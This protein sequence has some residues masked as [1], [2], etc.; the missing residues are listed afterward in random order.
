MQREKLYNLQITT[1]F[2]G[3]PVSFENERNSERSDFEVATK[4]C[5]LVKDAFVPFYLIFL[6]S[7]M[8]VC[9]NKT[10]QEMQHGKLY[11]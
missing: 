11:K 5:F 1:Y 8:F 7:Y 3:A 9:R 2:I 4:S 10:H 6:L